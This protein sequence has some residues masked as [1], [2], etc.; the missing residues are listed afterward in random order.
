MEAAGLA[1]GIVGLAGLFKNCIE[2]LSQISATR[3]MDRDYHILHAKLELEKECLL[4]W[5]RQVRLFDAE[6]QHD[7]RLDDPAVFAVVKQT[8]EAISILMTESATMQERYGLEMSGGTDFDLALPITTVTKSRLKQLADDF[9]KLQLRI[10]D[11]STGLTLPKKVRWVLADKDKFERLV[12]DL[13][14]FGSKLREL[15]TENQDAKT[16]KHWV[17][18]DLASV[19]DPK[20]LRLVYD[21]TADRNDLVAEAVAESYEKLCQKE[22]LDLLWFRSMDDRREGVSSA[23]SRTFEWALR[24]PGKYVEWGDLSA[25]MSVGSGLYWISGKAG[26]GKSTLMKYL[27]NS[28]E[29]LLLLRHWAGNLRLVFG[30]FFFWALGT[31]EQKSQEGLSRAILYQ[32]VEAEPGLLPVLLPRLWKEVLKG[33]GRAHFVPSLPSSAELSAAF[34]SF[35]HLPLPRHK[36]CFLVDGLDE[37]SG[38]YLD[39]ASFVKQLTRNQHVK[40]LVSSRPIPAYVDTF[41]IYPKLKLQDLTRPDIARYIQDTVGSHPYMS[42]LVSSQEAS[43]IDPTT[44]LSELT[45]KAVGVFLWVV[46]ACRSVLEGF[47]DF[48]RIE[49]LLHRV[50]ELPPELGDLFKHMLAKVEPR[51]RE[52]MAKTLR[53][54]YEKQHGPGLGSFDPTVY[55]LALAALDKSGMDHERLTLTIPSAKQQRAMCA[56][57][58]GRLRSRCGGLVEVRLRRSACRQKSRCLCHCLGVDQ[59]V[60]HSTVEFMHRT[61]SE[62]LGQEAWKLP[63]FRISDPMFNVNAA[64]C[65]MDLQIAKLM[66]EHLTKVPFS[67]GEPTYQYLSHVVTST[68]NFAQAY[69]KEVLDATIPILPRLEDVVNIIPRADRTGPTLQDKLNAPLVVAVEAGLANSVDHW[70]RTSSDE[71]KTLRFPLLHH[72]LQRPMIFE[73]CEY[74]INVNPVLVKSL[75]DHGHKPNQVFNNDGGLATTPWKEWLHS[76]E[77]LDKQDLLDTVE[78]TGELLKGGADPSPPGQESL[79]SIIRRSMDVASSG[80]Y[81][82]EFRLLLDLIDQASSEQSTATGL[83]DAADEEDEEDRHQEEYLFV[84]RPEQRAATAARTGQH[85]HRPDKEADPPETEMRKFRK[86]PLLEEPVG[87]S[88]LKRAKVRHG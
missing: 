28:E 73:R 3:S 8:L 20:I 33:H 15:F 12:Q 31:V 79:E 30:S 66:G 27:Y 5:A 37:F 67:M 7:R 72:A 14:D 74:A 88:S 21:A 10:K 34:E 42:T 45:D 49:E 54:C 55:T 35:R 39:A 62:F 50:D 38:S 78:V 69:D 52:Q 13:A 2:L 44:I 63:L 86:R 11:R 64:V 29:A 53:V 4:L 59:A 25:W 58:E 47:A 26:S 1:I 36:F 84:V 23:H 40:V 75:I 46:L 80:G 85:R 68:I 56:S 77:S 6:Q 24:K 57:M 22:I 43:D 32:I 48:D 60:A 76:L 51:Y 18:Q 61:V 41:S 65:I 19:R 87:S 71:A 16:F 81:P 17:H 83:E 82:N 70:L 9:G